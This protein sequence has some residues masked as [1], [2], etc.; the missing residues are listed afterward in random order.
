ML[1]CKVI[2]MIILIC[3]CMIIVAKGLATMTA[4][5]VAPAAVLSLGVMRPVIFFYEKVWPIT[6]L[7]LTMKGK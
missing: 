1:I 5:I 7:Q 2:S 6:T 4:L 3:Y